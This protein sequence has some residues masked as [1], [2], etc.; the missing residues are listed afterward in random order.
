MQ[1]ST[2]VSERYVR[3][4]RNRHC[5]NALQHTTTHLYVNNMR[6]QTETGTAKHRN[7]LQHTA[8][9]CNTLQHYTTHLYVN[10]MRGQKERGV[11]F[12]LLPTSI[13]QC[14]AVCCSVL[15]CVV[16]C[17]SVINQ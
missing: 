5:N 10:V 15:Q 14:G 11:R 6:G 7:T 12:R 8:T 16:V 1:C 17:C 9:H 2:P 3:A 13:L 4:E